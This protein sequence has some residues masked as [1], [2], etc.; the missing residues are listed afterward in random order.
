MDLMVQ[1][2]KPLTGETPASPPTEQHCG[3]CFHFLT[4]R[5]SVFSILSRTG[6]FHNTCFNHVP[7]FQYA[8]PALFFS[9]GTI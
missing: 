8:A 9:V 6:S 2:V 4:N 3:G 7:E 5:L 1:A